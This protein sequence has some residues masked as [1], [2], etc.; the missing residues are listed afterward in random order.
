MNNSIVIFC[1]LF[2]AF[3]AGIFSLFN[4]INNKEQKISE[5]R[6]AWIDGLRSDICGLTSS[7]IYI[8]YYSSIRIINNPNEAKDIEGSHKQFIT[9]SAS[10]L[11]KVNAQDPDGK[12]KK[13]NDNFLE[14]FDKIQIDFNAS[15]Y[16]EASKLTRELLDASQPLLKAE[17]E[18]V[19][20]GE[21]SY[22]KTKAFAWT[23]SLSGIFALILFLFVNYNTAEQTNS[24]KNQKLST[25]ISASISNQKTEINKIT[26]WAS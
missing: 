24:P 19:K 23:L 17:W 11:T 6:Q 20:N 22:K 16:I 25:K 3:V 5:F 13:I 18:R 14:V 12:L 1:T 21:S 4:L 10:I 26:L 2:T 15:N 9:C 7:L 8:S